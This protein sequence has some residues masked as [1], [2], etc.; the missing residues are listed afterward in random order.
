MPKIL[1]DA[2]DNLIRVAR[3]QA[4]TN[5]YPGMTIR[6]VAM[7]CGYSVGT[8]YNYFRSKDLLVAAFM[9]EDWN[10]EVEDMTA[11][12]AEVS[13][14]EALKV[15]YDGLG[16]YSKLYASVF[17]DRTAQKSHA[18]NNRSYHMRLLA[19]IADIIEDAL[20]RN[21]YTY[22]KLLPGFLAESL[23]MWEMRKC[24]YEDLSE[25]LNKLI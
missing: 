21:G 5:G 11:K 7:E 4:L 22:S 13:P 19:Q 24:S 15:I 9:L 2:R 14:A 17:E 6:S 18:L 10:R 12:C 16:H 23:L 3:K 20:K 8:V 25:I 1:D